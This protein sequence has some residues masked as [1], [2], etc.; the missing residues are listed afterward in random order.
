MSS[1]LL[2]VG[3]LTTDIVASGADYFPKTGDYAFATD[4]RIAAGG[5]GCNI[6]LMAAALLPPH[7]VSMVSVTSKDAH[8]LWRLPITA[9]QQAGVN[10]DFVTVKKDYAKLPSITLI[11]VD[12]QGRNQV[13]ALPGACW[14][15]S[16]EHIEAANTAYA[17]AGQKNGYSILTLECGIRGTAYAINK[18]KA[19]GLRVIFDPGGVKPGDDLTPMLDGI[20]LLKPNEHETKIMT[21]IDVD[22]FTTAE[23]AAQQLM[24]KGVENVLITV[25]ADG[26]YFFSHTIQKHIP[27]PRMPDKTEKDETACGDQVLAVLCASL[28]AGKSLEAAANDATIGGTLQFYRDGIKPVTATELAMAITAESHQES[29]SLKLRT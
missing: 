11:T 27:A 8:G 19:A 7:E 6:A 23:Q 21:D 12:K 9:L 26:A 17:K 5:K 28:Y 10:T 16:Q 22:D 29:R 18:A 15:L 13:I 1:S 4:F 3:S 24:R 2:V 20:Y 25:G 14:D